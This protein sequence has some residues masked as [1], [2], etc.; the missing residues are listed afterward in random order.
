[1]I[2]GLFRWNLKE[3]LIL[4]FTHSQLH[5]QLSLWSSRVNGK[6]LEVFTYISLEWNNTS[7]E[8]EWASSELNRSFLPTYNLYL[9]ERFLVY[10]FRFNQRKSVVVWTTLLFTTEK[11]STKLKAHTISCNFIPVILRL[12]PPTLIFFL[13][14]CCCQSQCSACNFFGEIYKFLLFSLLLLFP[15]P[16]LSVWR[17]LS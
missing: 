7:H 16:N 12:F 3:W 4:F 2:I 15:L 5:S 11:K 1:M 13:F 6:I 17:V 10:V 8:K 14:V 9:H